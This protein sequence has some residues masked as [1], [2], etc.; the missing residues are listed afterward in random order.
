M[1]ITKK[2]LWVKFA[3]FADQEKIAQ[4]REKIT[5][6]AI[7]DFWKLSIG[8][9]SLMLNG[10]LPTQLSKI[11]ESNKTTVCD[12]IKVINACEKFTKEFEQVMKS[13]EIPMDSKERKAAN[14]MIELSPTENILNFC[15][16]QFGQNPTKGGFN[17][18]ITLLEFLIRKKK[19]YN[20]TVF[21]KAYNK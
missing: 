17:E 14:A 9:F 4:I 12:A 8:E 11:L 7:F 5:D 19:V 21:Q 10:G 15:L 18:D 3:P 1:K 13:L 6:C 20:D 2:T 16:D